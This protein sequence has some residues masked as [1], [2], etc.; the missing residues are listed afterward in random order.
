MVFHPSFRLYSFLNI[1]S[2]SD[3][4]SPMSPAFWLKPLFPKCYR[5]LAS[6]THQGFLQIFER[7]PP[8]LY[9]YFCYTGTHA[10][11]CL[12][13]T[14][15]CSRS[16]CAPRSW[17]R[18]ENLTWTSTTSSLEAGWWVERHLWLV[19]KFF[20]GIKVNKNKSVFNDQVDWNWLSGGWP[21]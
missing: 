19:I 16:T 15:Y 20:E 10:V 4:D 6:W 14:S 13:G 1:T 7:F 12:R 9:V 3:Q 17:R 21:F 11:V 18:R 5:Y 8:Y 2:H